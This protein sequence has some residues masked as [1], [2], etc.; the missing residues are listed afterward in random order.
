MQPSGDPAES[1]RGRGTAEDAP[2]QTLSVPSISTPPC[3]A[4]PR[5]ALDT[6]AAGRNGEGPTYFV[7]VVP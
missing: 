2:T 4:R 6:A 5:V 3:H 1:F 7:L